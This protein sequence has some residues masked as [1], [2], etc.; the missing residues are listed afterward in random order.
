MEFT[1][2][3][4]IKKILSAV[5]KKYIFM[6]TYGTYQSLTEKRKRNEHSNIKRNAGFSLNCV[7]YLYIYFAIRVYLNMK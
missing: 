2:E 4:R 7:F 6:I 3:V 1:Y 5:E